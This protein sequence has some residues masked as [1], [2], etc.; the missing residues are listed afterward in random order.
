MKILSLAF[1]IVCLPLAVVHTYLF[2][3]THSG[4]NLFAALVC[5]FATIL[6]LDILLRK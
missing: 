6:H 4:L 2:F 3:I 5:S 1:V